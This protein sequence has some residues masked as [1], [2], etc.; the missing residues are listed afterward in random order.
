MGGQR[1]WGAR[2]TRSTSPV[3]V[4]A[5]ELAKM[6]QSVRAKIMGLELYS[7]VVYARWA[8][9]RSLSNW[10]PSPIR[11]GQQRQWMQQ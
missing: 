9:A 11:V 7:L 6:A 2:T 5:S 4:G 3:E 10:A 1:E 8:R